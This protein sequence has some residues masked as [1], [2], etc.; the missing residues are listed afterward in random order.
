MLDRKRATRHTGAQAACLWRI[1]PHACRA[2]LTHHVSSCLNLSHP[3]ASGSL[4]RLIWRE[5][6]MSRP[7]SAPDPAHGAAHDM[8]HDKTTS[9]LPSA[10]PGVSLFCAN[11]ALIVILALSWLASSHFLTPQSGQPAPAGAPSATPTATPAFGP[12]VA[13]TPVAPAATAD[14]ST[15]TPA[16]AS[17]GPPAHPTATP[18]PPT[19]TPSPIPTATATPARPTPTPTF[20]PA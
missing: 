19:P 17:P 10:L 14:E 6:H 9:A 20:S 15:P 18:V 4:V 3:D 5:A 7:D 16:S 12:P 11:L 1:S 2:A 13:L 8:P